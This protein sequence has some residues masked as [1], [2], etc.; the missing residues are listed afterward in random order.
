LGTG[1]LSCYAQPGQHWT[2][3]EIDPVVIG[4]ARDPAQFTFLSRC[5]PG[6]PIIIGDARLSL[7]RAPAAAADILVVDAFSSDSVPM[8]LLTREAFATYRKHLSPRGLLLVHISNRYLD[9]K[10]V[11]AAAASDGWSVRQRSYMPD[12]NGV[13]Q[14][15]TGSLWVAL[16]SSPEVI[17]QL[18]ASNPEARWEPLKPRPGFAPWT[19]EHSSILPIIKGWE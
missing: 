1:A 12:A 17:D 15:E 11:I 4:I 9:M 5:Q 18:V 8:H 16:S 7:E 10:P 3:Y 14:H 13:K 2:F 19:D 6:V